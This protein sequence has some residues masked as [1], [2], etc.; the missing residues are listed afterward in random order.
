MEVE[1]PIKESPLLI[2]RSHFHSGRIG[3]GRQ[4]YTCLLPAAAKCGNVSLTF[5]KG[6]AMQRA[7]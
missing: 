4:I 5:I 1:G 7:I 3:S 2:G 6:I